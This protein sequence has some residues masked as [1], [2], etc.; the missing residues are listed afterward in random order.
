MFDW[1]ILHEKRKS[2]MMLSSTDQ[3]NTPEQ[4]GRG[5][6][7]PIPKHGTTNGRQGQGYTELNANSTVQTSKPPVPPHGSKGVKNQQQSNAFNN[8]SPGSKER[9][10]SRKQQKWWRKMV[11]WCGVKESDEN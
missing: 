11:F 4:K 8:P 7:P 10:M 2:S 6:Q 3:S 1:I 5:P 9:K